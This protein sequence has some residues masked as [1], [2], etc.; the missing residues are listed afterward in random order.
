M[1][2]NANLTVVDTLANYFPDNDS[3]AVQQLFQQDPNIDVVASQKVDYEI[4]QAVFAK[5]DAEHKNILV[6]ENQ[7]SRNM[8]NT[9]YASVLLADQRVLTATEFSF[10][11]IFDSFVLAYLLGTLQPRGLYH[12]NEATT[13]ENLVVNGTSDPVPF[14]LPSGSC[15]ATTTTSQGTSGHGTSGHGTSGHGTGYTGDFGTGGHGYSGGSGSIQ[16]LPLVVDLARLSNLF[17]QSEMN[18]IE[19]YWQNFAKDSSFGPFCGPFAIQLLG[20]AYQFINGCISD[21]NAIS[22][23]LY[24]PEFANQITSVNESG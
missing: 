19:T 4:Q 23:L 2:S 20:D 7:F 6:I 17:T 14:T 24:A 10:Q 16:N 8:S 13:I 15:S 1:C 5:D 12:A 9:T 21:Q 3:L 22:G 11:S 18:Y